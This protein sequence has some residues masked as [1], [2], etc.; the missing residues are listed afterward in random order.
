MINLGI[1]RVSVHGLIGNA[2]G[3]V[4]N[5]FVSQFLSLNNIPGYNG[6]M[7]DAEYDDPEGYSGLPY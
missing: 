2:Y 1:S 4:R 6:D 7:M 3:N 5:H